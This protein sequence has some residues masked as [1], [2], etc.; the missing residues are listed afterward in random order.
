MGLLL[1]NEA[2][3]V[4][5]AQDREERLVA[6][7]LPAGQ[8]VR[9]VEAGELGGSALWIGSTLV[10]G[11]GAVST[12]GLAGVRLV[13]AALFLTAAAPKWANPKVFMAKVANYRLVP[14]PLVPVVGGAVMAIE[15]GSGLLLA[16]DVLRLWAA[17]AAAVLLAGF[18]AAMGV[19]LLRDRRID[20]GCGAVD[21]EIG[22][23]LVGRDVVLAVA[24]GAVAISSSSVPSE[25]TVAPGITVVATL[26]GSRL[27][28]SA[29]RM[30]ALGHLLLRALERE[31][32]C[33][34]RG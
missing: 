15:A 6:R 9:L 19:N 1:A 31:P 29:L 11:V 4:A 22:W 24:A 5:W 8:K 18:A 30:G 25:T 28:R 3:S 33:P 32:A 17:V 27:V 16:A 26:A 14:V 2:S 7:S 10:A 20:C 34:G 21:R 23:G 12:V 13:V